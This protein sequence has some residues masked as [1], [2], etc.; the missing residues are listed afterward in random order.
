MIVCECFM[1]CKSTPVI[2]NVKIEPLYMIFIHSRFLLLFTENQKFGIFIL[3]FPK[4]F[5]SLHKVQ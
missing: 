1:A 2:T 4:S 5:I 3:T